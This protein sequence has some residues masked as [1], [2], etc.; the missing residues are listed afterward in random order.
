MDKP[1]KG[2]FALCGLKCLGL[3][4]EDQPIEITYDDGNKGVAYVGIHLT[5]KVTDIGK[6][7]SSRNPIVVGHI[8][9]IGDE[10]E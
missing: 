3:I 2:S 1:R 6:P 7:W 5:N 10:N 8:D 4:T 9:S